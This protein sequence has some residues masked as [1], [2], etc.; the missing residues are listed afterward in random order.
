MGLFSSMNYGKL[1]L[2][3]IK[4]FF[5]PMF[6]QF[7]CSSI[8]MMYFINSIVINIHTK[9]YGKLAFQVGRTVKHLQTYVCG[10]LKFLLSSWPLVLPFYTLNVFGSWTKTSSNDSGLFSW[11]HGYHDREN[12][13]WRVA[14]NKV[15]MLKPI[16]QNWK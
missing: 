3:I 16:W 13:V 15:E 4:S 7:L 10:P 14:G 5:S 2:N 8:K 11:C 12:P 9:Q 1:F 6:L